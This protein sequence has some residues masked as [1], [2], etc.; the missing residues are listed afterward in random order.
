MNAS[1][2]AAQQA[3]SLAEPR[4]LVQKKPAQQN[5]KQGAMS[6]WWDSNPRPFGPEW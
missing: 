6:K 3:I 1:I 4:V 5:A 2:H